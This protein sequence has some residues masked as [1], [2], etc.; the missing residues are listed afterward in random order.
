M[1]LKQ[2]SGLGFPYRREMAM[3]EQ[4]QQIDHGFFLSQ[5]EES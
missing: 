4:L 3:S 5:L 2:R 1:K